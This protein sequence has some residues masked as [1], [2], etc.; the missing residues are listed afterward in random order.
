[1]TTKNLVLIVSFIAPSFSGYREGIANTLAD[2]TAE[3]KVKVI[4]LCDASNSVTRESDNLHK[5]LR[6]IKIYVKELA[7]HYPFQSEIFCYPISDNLVSKQMGEAISYDIRT[8]AQLESEKKKVEGLLNQLDDRMDSL[9]KRTANSCILLSIKRAIS[10]LHEFGNAPGGEYA[11]ELVIISDMIECCKVSDAKA[12]EM[13]VL[14]TSKLS[15]ALKNF[16]T[17][18][19]GLNLKDLDLTVRIFVN[20][21]W[22]GDKFERIRKCW[23]TWFYK[24]GLRPENLFIYTDDPHLKENRYLHAM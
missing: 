10:R 3:R 17:T 20:S 1:M 21:P 9:A 13:S 4:V 7:R 18:N 14:N 5:V 24:M 16:E 6:N 22:M 8:T 2:R 19:T 23:E 12:V 11:N 15:E